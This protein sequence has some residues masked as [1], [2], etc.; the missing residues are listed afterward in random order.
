[1]VQVTVSAKAL[2]F[3][4]VIVGA[5]PPWQTA[6]VPAMVAEGVGRTV[7]VAVPEMVFEQVGV[8]W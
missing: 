8:V 2:G 7:M 3:V 4:K 1:M 5:V 6:V